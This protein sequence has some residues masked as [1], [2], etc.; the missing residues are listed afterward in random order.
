MILPQLLIEYLV[1]GSLSLLWLLPLLG[2]DL[3]AQSSQSLVAIAAFA[4]SIYVMGMCIDFVAYLFVSHFPTRKRSIKSKIR[5]MTLARFPAE[6]RDL[7]PVSGNGRS[8]QIGIFLTLHAPDLAREVS[9]RN[10]RDRIARSTS[11]NFGIAA[12]YFYCANLDTKIVVL[13]T[14]GSLLAIVMW[15]FHERNS[16][17]FEFRSFLEI[18]N[19][20]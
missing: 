5:R 4:P 2:L 18:Q 14:I 20:E 17:D 6:S 8:A 12:I 19:N 11:I 13:S 15:F 16:A 7:L 3:S 9:A 10:S 1:I